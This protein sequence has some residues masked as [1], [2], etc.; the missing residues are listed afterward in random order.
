MK[1]ALKPLLERKKRRKDSKPQNHLEQKKKKKT[2][3]VDL[4]EMFETSF[5][6]LNIINF[7]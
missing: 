3:I 4:L 6:R 1:V 5:D 7:I 2:W